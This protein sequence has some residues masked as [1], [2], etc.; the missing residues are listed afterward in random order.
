MKFFISWM[1]QPMRVAR[2]MQHLCLCIAATGSAGVGNVARLAT[3]AQPRM[4]GLQQAAV[5]GKACAQYAGAPALAM[6]AQYAGLFCLGV[7]ATLIP[8]CR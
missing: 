2:T 7:K 3:P 1:L 8:C 4:P 5:W 6:R